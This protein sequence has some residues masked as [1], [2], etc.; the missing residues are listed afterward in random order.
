MGNPLVEL[1]QHGQSVWLDYIRRKALLSGDVKALIENDG[2]R[3]MTANPSIFQAAIAAGDDYDE[4]IQK[5]VRAG[6]DPNTIY[7]TLAVE[8]IQTACDQFRSV[9]DATDGADGFVSLEV[10]PNLAHDTQGTIEEARRLWAWVNRPN[11]MIKVPGLPAGVPAIE[12]LLSEGINVNVTLLF[13][14][15]AYEAVAWAY[16]KA[17]ETRVAA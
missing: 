9:Y 8:D 2:L 10:S 6:S 13:A 12:T 7:E 17:L 15:E 11:L 16:I 14:I 5:G 4:T 1:Q 3:G